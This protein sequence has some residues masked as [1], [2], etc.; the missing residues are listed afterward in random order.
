[1]KKNNKILYIGNNLS[2]KTNYNSTML[3][4]SI[5]LSQEGYIVKKSSDKNNKIL[6]LLDMCITLLKSRKKTD[7]VLIDTFSTLNFYYAFIISQLCRILKKKYISI[8]HGGNLPMRLKKNKFLCGLIFNNSYVNVAPSMYLKT[9]FDD[10]EYKTV[11]IPN[12]IEVKNYQFKER[13]EIAP[14]ILWVRA[15]YSIY[16]PKLA[17]ETLKVLKNEYPEAALCMVGPEKDNSYIQCKELVEKYSLESFVTFTGVLKKEEWHKLSK[18]YDI[19]INTTNIDNTPVSVI[20]AMALGLPVVSTNVGGIPFLIEHEVSGILVDKNN[21]VEMSNAISNL[22]KKNNLLIAKK[23]RY[24]AES[25]DWEQVK[26]IWNSIL[27]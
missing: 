12:T 19:F 5:L 18:D 27:Q 20:E 14:K 26:Q 15:F 9:H 3:T 22:L 13:K 1:M 7:Y 6:R 4:L 24:K 2:K 21:P 8:L 23:A 25:F 16:N 17:I 11:Y 10:K